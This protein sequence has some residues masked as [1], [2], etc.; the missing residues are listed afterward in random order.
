[1]S[2]FDRA[3]TYA[4]VVDI[5]VQQLSV[6][7]D[8]INGPTTLASLGADSLDRIEL[9]MKFEETF[10]LEITDQAADSFT[11]VNAIVDYI[12]KERKR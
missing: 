9:T 5:I 10:G 11:T 3:D 7:K 4:K 1:M 12:D 2:S 8:D 6:K